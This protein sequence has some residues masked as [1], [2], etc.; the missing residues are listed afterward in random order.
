MMCGSCRRRAASSMRSAT[1]VP[2]QTAARPRLAAR[3]PSVYRR[4]GAFSL[5]NRHRASPHREARPEAKTRRRPEMRAH[6]KGK[7]ELGKRFA[8]VIG[9]AAAGVM[10][11]GA[12]MASATFP[13]TEGRIAFSAF[14]IETGTSEIYTANPNG[15]DVQ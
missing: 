15:G 1:A 10:A 13:G 6:T 4:V 5:S 12:Q 3:V 11:L 7:Y 14:F 8:I 9:V 2:T